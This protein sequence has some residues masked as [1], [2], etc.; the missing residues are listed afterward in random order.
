MGTD[1]R[2]GANIPETGVFTGKC[3][4][5]FSMYLFSEWVSPLAVPF[6]NLHF[7]HFK[8]SFVFS[9]RQS[10]S[11]FLLSCHTIQPSSPLNPKTQ[12]MGVCTF[13]LSSQAFYSLPREKGGKKL[14]GFV[15]GFHTPASVSQTVSP[16]P[17]CKV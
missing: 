2:S 11:L 5:A 17:G 12:K 7:D 1:G 6:R 8:Y 10:S 15:L 3:F 13:G 16:K 9:L 14:L 4:P